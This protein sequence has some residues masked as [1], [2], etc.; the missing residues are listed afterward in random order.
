MQSREIG[1]LH[2]SFSSSD[3]NIGAF[4]PID[5]SLRSVMPRREVEF[6]NGRGVGPQLVRDQRAR[7]KAMSVHTL[8]RQLQ[9]RAPIAFR[10]D[11]DIQHLAILIDRAP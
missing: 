2:L 6:T 5:L 4:N 9:G 11:Q 1:A 8:P 3:R 10:L 7:C